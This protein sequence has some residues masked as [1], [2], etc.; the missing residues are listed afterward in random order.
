MPSGSSSS[1]ASSAHW[2]CR[3]PVLK[4]QVP[5]TTA[6][7][8]VRVPVPVGEMTPAVRRSGVAYTS[9]C[10][11]SGNSATIQFVAIPMVTTQ[12]VEAQ[13]RAISARTSFCSATSASNP[14]R[15]RGMPS[16]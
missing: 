11:S 5:V 1:R 2:A 9:S 3:Q 4:A 14:P 15:E 7:P 10:A 8:S 16:R 12:L 13:P 6:P